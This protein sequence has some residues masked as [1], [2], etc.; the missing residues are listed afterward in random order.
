MNDMNDMNDEELKKNI[1]YIIHIISLLY[2]LIP[3]VI[4]KLGFGLLHKPRG[5]SDR[6]SPP[7]PDI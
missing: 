7:Y 4:Q 3:N 5:F 1:I 6:K 2:A